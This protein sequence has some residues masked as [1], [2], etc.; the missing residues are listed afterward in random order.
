MTAQTDPENDLII[1]VKAYIDGSLEPVEGVIN[2]NSGDLPN[3]E[4]LQENDEWA[5]FPELAFNLGSAGTTAIGAFQYDYVAA[6]ID[7]A[8]A[9][10]AGSFSPGT[11]VPKWELY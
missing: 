9:P 8:F 3:P 5:G 10:E 6:T 1:N 11:A 2:R 4:D 7:G